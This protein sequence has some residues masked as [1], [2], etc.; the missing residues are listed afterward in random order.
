MVLV[1]DEDWEG[2]SDGVGVTTGNSTIDGILLSGAGIG[3][4]S[5]A[6]NPGAGGALSLRANGTSGTGGWSAFWDFAAVDEFT[7][8][9]W[10]RLTGL[11]TYAWPNGDANAGSFAKYFS[12][13]LTNPSIPG[14][15]FNCSL[16]T[17]GGMFVTDPLLVTGTQ[18]LNADGTLRVDHL[19]DSAGKL[20]IAAATDYKITVQGKM[21]DDFYDLLIDDVQVNTVPLPMYGAGD[22]VTRLQLGNFRGGSVIGDM[23]IG[24]VTLDNTLIPAGP[25]PSSGGGDPF[26]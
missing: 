8:E 23:W 15:G 22:V 18:H 3:Q 17:L 24:D 4:F 14:A 11:G 16:G 6:Q 13:G 26:S 7:F 5:N 12:V 10:I 25:G 21:S 19:Y 1:I 20:F 9:T 2:G